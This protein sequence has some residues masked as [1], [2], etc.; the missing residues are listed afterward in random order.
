MR[1]VV[2]G[3]TGTIGSAVTSALAPAHQVVRA[4]RHGP[5]A[6]DIANPASIARLFDSVSEI[7]A[8][9]C[10]AASVKSILLDALS[11]DDI[12]Q[13]LQVKLIG[14]VNLVCEALQHLRDG[15][16]ITLTTGTLPQPTLGNVLDAL[17]NGA[18]KSFVK[19]AA[20]EMPRGLR[21]ND[22]SPTR[23]KETLEKLGLDS[24]GAIPAADVARAYVVAI[25]G[26]LQG[27]T[28][29]PTAL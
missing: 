4:S 18:L 2:I 14:Q 13:A 9:V 24:A 7:D 5:V 12:A 15:G 6:V 16:S 22:V 21:L 27:Q 29:V 25:G 28:I 8:I 1:V 26:L 17:V 10:C 23:V 20:A 3:A 11:E 19:A